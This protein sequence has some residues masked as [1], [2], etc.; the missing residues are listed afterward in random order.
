M[1]FQ[2]AFSAVHEEES[3]LLKDSWQ[4]PGSVDSLMDIEHR[5]TLRRTRKRARA[6]S[7]W[8]ASALLGFYSLLNLTGCVRHPEMGNEVARM[9][10]YDR[11][12]KQPVVYNAYREYP[13]VDPRTGEATLVPASYCS[14]CEVWFPSPPIEVRER[15]PQ[16]ALCPKGHSLD[17]DGPWP[18]TELEE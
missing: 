11:A 13:V 10:Y 17:M 6:R 15:N 1:I 9:V 4:S 8:V 12:T 3:P 2:I 7:Q 5:Q 14:T 16:S 18:D